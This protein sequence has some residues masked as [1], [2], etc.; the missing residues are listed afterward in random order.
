[1]LFPFTLPERRSWW[2]AQWTIPTNQRSDRSPINN[3]GDVHLYLPQTGSEMMFGAMLR[4][5]VDPASTAAGEWASPA[6]TQRRQDQ[7][8]KEGS[9]WDCELFFLSSWLWYY[10]APLMRHSILS[11]HFINS[12]RKREGYWIYDN[13]FD[14]ML[15]SFVPYPSPKYNNHSSNFLKCWINP[16][17]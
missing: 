2:E 11:Y 9:M 7:W 10:D 13:L 1:M 12:V 17:L 6:P 3:P 4:W 8:E 14:K 16:W 15:S 5:V